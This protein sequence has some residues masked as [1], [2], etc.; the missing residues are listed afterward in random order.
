M[1][2][3]ID[4]GVIEILALVIILLAVISLIPQAAQWPLLS[5][6]VLLGGVALFLVGKH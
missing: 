5:V 4:V 3:E 2:E 6:A 1:G